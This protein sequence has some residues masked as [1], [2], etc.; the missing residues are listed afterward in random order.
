MSEAAGH[1]S[2]ARGRPRQDGTDAEAPV[3]DE[4]QVS[5]E[6]GS[7]VEAEVEGAPAH[8]TDASPETTTEPRDETDWAHRLWAQ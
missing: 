2:T 3:T 5:D 6:A 4:K 7:G 1:D 8:D